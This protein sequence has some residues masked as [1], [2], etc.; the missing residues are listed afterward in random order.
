MAVHAAIA[1]IAVGTGVELVR[2]VETEF[3]PEG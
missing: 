2:R 3:L 1:R